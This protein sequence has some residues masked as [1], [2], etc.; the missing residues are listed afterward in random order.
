MPPDT[1]LLRTTAD[2]LAARGRLLP[3]N[4]LLVAVAAWRADGIPAVLLWTTLLLT[5]AWLH[6]RI[7][8][9]AAIFRRWAAYG[10]GTAAFDAALAVLHLRRKR[11]TAPLAASCHGAARLCKQLLLLTALQAAATAWLAGIR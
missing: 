10:A 2:L 1:I 11:H 5:S 8:F 9:D 3:Y 4:L 7:A 6:W